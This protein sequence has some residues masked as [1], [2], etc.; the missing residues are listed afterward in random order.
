MQSTQHVKTAQQLAAI[1]HSGSN[2]TAQQLQ[3]AIK[4]NKVTFATIVQCSLVDLSKD[5]KAIHKIYKIATT[6]VTINASYTN[7]VQKTASTISS[8]NASNVANF[9]AQASNYTALNSNCEAVVALNSNNS[10]HYL[11]AIANKCYAAQYFC[12]NT[13]SIVSKA[14]VASLCTASAAKAM[15]NTSNVVHNVSNNIAH[16]VAP[17]TFALANM[18]SIAVNSTVIQ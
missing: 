15:L 1:V 5:N 11:K 14:Y 17:R 9:V 16:T 7:A 6:N 18:H 2:V 10:K 4:N 8:N 13:N 12:A 3:A